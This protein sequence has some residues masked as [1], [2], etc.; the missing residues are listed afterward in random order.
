MRREQETRKRL[1]PFRGWAFLFLLSFLALLALPGMLWAEEAAIIAAS[2]GKVEISRGESPWGA[3]VPGAILHW[4]DRIRAGKGGRA[5]IVLVDERSVDIHEHTLLVL[6]K[7]DFT[8]KK[9]LGK[10]ISGLFG[11]VKNKFT[12]TKYTNA[13]LG[14]VGAVRGEAE[15]EELEDYPLSAK[16][17]EELTAKREA[18]EESKAFSEPTA[19]DYLLLGMLLEDYEQYRS[20]EKAYRSSMKQ[21]ELTAATAA[22]FLIDLYVKNDLLAKAKNLQTQFTK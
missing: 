19:G 18:L 13:A 7:K 17:E 4:G 15:E 6:N 5:T 20:A 12:D 8:T 3:A 21:D 1:T 10:I 16:E 9:G 22:S 11:L 14:E 2:R